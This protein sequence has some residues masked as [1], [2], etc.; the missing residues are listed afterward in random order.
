MKSLNSMT[1]DYGLGL[2][3]VFDGFKNAAFGSIFWNSGKTTDAAI[4]SIAGTYDKTITD[5]FN[6]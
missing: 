5:F 4:D 3:N 1:F 2:D 6:K